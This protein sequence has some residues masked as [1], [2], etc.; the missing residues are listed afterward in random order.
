LSYAL[1]EEEELPAALTAVDYDLRH[2]D[3]QSNLNLPG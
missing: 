1:G 2:A 3:D